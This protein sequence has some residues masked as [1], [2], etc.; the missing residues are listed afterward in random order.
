MK[1]MKWINKKLTQISVF[2]IEKMHWENTRSNQ[3]AISFFIGNAIGW[4][5]ILLTIK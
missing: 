2:I 5:I 4:M 3:W 1:K